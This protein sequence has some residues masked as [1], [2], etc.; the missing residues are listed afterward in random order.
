[1]TEQVWTIK[2]V[3]QW[4]SNFL[5]TA[6]SDSPRLDAELLLARVLDCRRLDLY[7]E[8]HKPLLADERKGYRELIKRRAAGE[9]VAYILGTRDFFG[10]T[11]QVNRTTLIPRPDTELLVEKVLEHYQ[12]GH[13]WQGLDIGTGSGCI[14]ISIKKNRPEAELWAW[15]KSPEALEVARKN[16]EELEAAVRF[17]EVDALKDQSWEASEL[18]FDFIVSNPPYIS[19]NE[20]SS[21]PVSVRDYEPGLALF[22]SDHGLAFYK[23]ISQFAPTRLQPGG[24]VFLEVGHRQAHEVCSILEDSGWSEIST[25]RDLAGHQRVIIARFDR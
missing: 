2:D 15:D 9:P 13:A 10:L 17:R 22:A 8:H 11:F 3:I 12:A 14:A 1:M 7:L 25:H 4:S 19:E 18:C 24:K 23:A 20:R 5:K 6:G 21:L 16:S